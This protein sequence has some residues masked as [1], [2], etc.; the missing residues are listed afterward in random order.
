MSAFGL[1]VGGMRCPPIS[2]ECNSG[3]GIVCVAKALRVVDANQPIP[4]LIID[5]A[6]GHIPV[7]FAGLHVAGGG[8]LAQLWIVQV[9][10]HRALGKALAVWHNRNA[11]QFVVGET[12]ELTMNALGF[13][14]IAHIGV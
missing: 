2:A 3:S 11:L 10:I 6:L 8:D 1:D 12:V 7:V 9:D 14:G 4:E 13:I 5:L